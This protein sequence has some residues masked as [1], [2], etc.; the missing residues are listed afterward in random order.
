VLSTGDG[1]FRALSLHLRYWGSAVFGSTA[2]LS[3][4][5]YEPSRRS[6]FTGLGSSVDFSGGVFNIATDADRFAVI[7]FDVGLGLA[8]KR[9]GSN[10]EAAMDSI[11]VLLTF[12]RRLGTL[13]VIGAAVYVEESME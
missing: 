5:R 6:C 8:G 3:S 1:A 7:L 9:S 11:A 2:F 13:L 4:S 10:S 12:A